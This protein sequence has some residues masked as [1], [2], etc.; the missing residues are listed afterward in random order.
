MRVHVSRLRG[1]TAN[2][3]DDPSSLDWRKGR[4]VAGGVTTEKKH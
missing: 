4:G 1:M 3:A 2:R